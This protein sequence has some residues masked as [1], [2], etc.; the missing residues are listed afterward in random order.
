MV[1]RNEWIGESEKQ[2][3]KLPN[4]D[5]YWEESGGLW[6]QNGRPFLSLEAI[7]EGSDWGVTIWVSGGAGKGLEWGACYGVL[8]TWKFREMCVR[9]LCVLSE[10]V[11]QS[12]K[13]MM[14]FCLSWYN[15]HD[16]ICLL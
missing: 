2:N 7:L 15:T 12:G 14:F 8:A 6:E 13:K 1:L 4:G 5:G 9:E 16:K 11:L 3:R 10:W